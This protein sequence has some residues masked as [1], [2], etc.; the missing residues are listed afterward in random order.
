MHNIASIEI[1]VHDYCIVTVHLAGQHAGNYFC[2]QTMRNFILFFFKNDLY[3]LTLLLGFQKNT[4]R[5]AAIKNIQCYFSQNSMYCLLWKLTFLVSEIYYLT[6]VRSWN[7]CVLLHCPL[8][9]C[10]NY[11]MRRHVCISF[12]SFPT[13]PE[14]VTWKQLNYHCMAPCSVVIR[15]FIDV[16]DSQKCF[17]TLMQTTAATNKGSPCPIIH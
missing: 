7:S 11:F 1:M 4:N 3:N 8:Q 14:L 15:Y 2:V 17:N 5:H 13:I 10:R 12:L 16:L 9:K 6:A